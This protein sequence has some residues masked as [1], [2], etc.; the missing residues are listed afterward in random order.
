MRSP[1]AF[2]R[3]DLKC[4]LAKVVLARYGRFS[5][6]RHVPTGLENARYSSCCCLYCHRHVLQS[7]AGSS[8]V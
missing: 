8:K 7:S 2:D 4:L 5:N 6:R 1:P 3:A